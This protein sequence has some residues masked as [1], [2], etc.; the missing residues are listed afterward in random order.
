MVS[1]EVGRYKRNECDYR[2]SRDAIVDK[3]TVKHCFGQCC[4]ALYRLVSRGI[5][6]NLIAL[7]CIV[8]CILYYVEFKYSFAQYN[9]VQWSEVRCSVVDCNLL[10]LIYFYLI[11]FH[12]KSLGRCARRRVALYRNMQCTMGILAE[13]EIR[14][15]CSIKC[16]V[17]TTITVLYS[18]KCERTLY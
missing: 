18:I 10:Y 9:A 2:C 15:M 6:S 7:S 3:R 8:Q 13:F 11:T 5:A 17:V 4:V 1:R 16:R 12:S 14:F